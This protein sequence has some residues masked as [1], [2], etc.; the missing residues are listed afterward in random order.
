MYINLFRIFTT[1]HIFYF[2]NLGDKEISL[3]TIFEKGF[4]FEGYLK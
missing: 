4:Y 1:N 3:W 2:Y